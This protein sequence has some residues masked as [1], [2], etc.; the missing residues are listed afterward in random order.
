MEEKGGSFE[1][2]WNVCVYLDDLLL[3]YMSMISWYINLHNG[4]FMLNIFCWW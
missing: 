1:S 3:L 4:K 2:T